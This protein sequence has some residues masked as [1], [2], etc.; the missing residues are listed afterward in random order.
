MEQKVFQNN[1]KWIGKIVISKI[2]K[3]LSEKDQFQYNPSVSAAILLVWDSL[4]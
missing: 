3:E 4:V 1:M 2:N